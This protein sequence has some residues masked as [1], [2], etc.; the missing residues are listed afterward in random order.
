[1]NAWPSQALIGLRWFHLDRPKVLFRWVYG[2][3]NVTH[4]G[5]QV[6]RCL[7]Q[8]IFN[9][10]TSPNR[11]RQIGSST[12]YYDPSTYTHLTHFQKRQVSRSSH[13][14]SASASACFPLLYRT[15]FSSSFLPTIFQFCLDITFNKSYV[16]QKPK[17][18]RINYCFKCQ[19]LE[20]PDSNWVSLSCSISYLLYSVK[21]PYLAVVFHT[22]R[23]RKPNLFSYRLSQCYLL[24]LDKQR[25]KSTLSIVCELLAVSTFASLSH[26]K[27]NSGC[28]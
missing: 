22:L 11:R 21:Q 18:T 23:V 20:R 28:K 1:M 3:C 6:L 7:D 9:F 4:C 13:I 10:T 14:M 24:Y 2:F 19:W 26:K 25:A 16:A 15:S 27:T 12:K 5:V 17:Q 8:S